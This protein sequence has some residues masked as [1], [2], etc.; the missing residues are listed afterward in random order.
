MFLFC[1]PCERQ[2]TLRL[3]IG[4]HSISRMLIPNPDLDFCSFSPQIHFCANLRMWLSEYR[5]RFERKI[6]IIDKLIKNDCI[7][8]LLLLCLYRSQNNKLSQWKKECWI[9]GIIV[10]IKIFLI[11]K[12]L[13]Q[14]KLWNKMKTTYKLLHNGPS[15]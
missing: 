7:K 4:T 11:D 2:K 5:E 1:T 14:P 12:A 8:C 13:L 9:N 10:T 3:T 15:I 6:K